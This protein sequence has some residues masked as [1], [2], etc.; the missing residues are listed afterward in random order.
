[1]TGD[2]LSDIKIPWPYRAHD[3]RAIG[4]N[5]TSHALVGYQSGWDRAHSYRRAAEILAEH[6]STHRADVDSVFFAFAACWRHCIEVQLKSLLADL[7]R[8]FDVDAG[9][10]RHHDVLQLWNEARPLLVRA[11]PDEERRDRSVV[12]RLLHQLADLDPLGEDFRYARRKDGSTSLGG[13]DSIDITAFHAGMLAMST[14]L[15]AA[16]DMTADDLANKADYE[17]YLEEQVP[18]EY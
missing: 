5:W 2:R 10:P 17:G 8:L 14:Y 7:R 1:M 13:V 6:V 12:G 4:T 9:A 16:L 15:D 11:H 18:T 3:L